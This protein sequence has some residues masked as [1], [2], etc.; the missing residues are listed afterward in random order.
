MPKAGK[1]E[2]TPRVLLGRE[3]M[4]LRGSRS[5]REVVAQHQSWLTLDFLTRAEEGSVVLLSESG[6]L[7]DLIRV[8]NLGRKHKA[9]QARIDSLLRQIV[10]VHCTDHIE[11]TQMPPLPRSDGKSR[12][13]SNEAMQE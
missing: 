2:A 11:A 12:W 6:K 9:L 10:W 1:V 4:R 5:R 8:Y 7:G 3:L 13:T